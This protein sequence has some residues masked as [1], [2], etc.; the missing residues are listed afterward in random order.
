MEKRNMILH[1]KMKYNLLDLV[2]VLEPLL[3]R[4]LL[5]LLLFLVILLLKTQNSEEN[6]EPNIPFFVLKIVPSKLIKSLVLIHMLIVLVSANLLFTL[7]QLLISVVKHISL[8][9]QD[10]IFIYHYL[11]M[12]LFLKNLKEN[13]DLE[14]SEFLEISL[15]LVCISKKNINPQTSLLIGK[16][17]MLKEVLLDLLNGHSPLTQLNMVFPSNKT[18]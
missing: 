18:P 4:M 16:S 3:L 8:L 11:E 1:S 2:L 5:K 15:I 6:Q 9:L 13:M 14:L 7:D 12:E 17:L 10:L